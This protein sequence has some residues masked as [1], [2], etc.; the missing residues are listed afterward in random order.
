MISPKLIAADIII[1]CLIFRFDFEDISCVINHPEA[2]Q[3]NIAITVKITYFIS[4]SR[5][6]RAYHQNTICTSTILLFTVCLHPRVDHVF[7]LFS[8]LMLE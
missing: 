1:L 7:D 4:N 3:I 5:V 6:S 2:T 8:I